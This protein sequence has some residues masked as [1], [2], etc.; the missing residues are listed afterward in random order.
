MSNYDQAELAAEFDDVVREDPS[1]LTYNLANTYGSFMG[2]TERSL[3]AEFVVR[4][5]FD[6]QP[7][8]QRLI[9]QGKQYD[10]DAVFLSK[11][12]PEDTPDARPGVE[13]YFKETITPEQMATV[14]E[15]LRDKGV[16]GFTY[17]TDMRFDD[18]VNRQTRPGDPETA[19]LNGLRFQYVPEFDDT[20]DP[21]KA[22][23]SYNK[24]ADLFRSVVNDTVSDGNVSDARITYYDTEVYFR[25]DYD[26][27]LSRTIKEGSSGAGGDL[28]R[29]AN[30]PKS[31][32]GAEVGTE[33]PTDVPDG[34]VQKT[35]SQEITALNKSGDPL[36][37]NIAVDKNGTDYADLI[38]N[39][40]KKFESRETASLK[41]YVGKRVGIVRTGAGPAEVIGS[42]EIGQ[43]IEVNEKQFNQLRDQHLVAEDSSFNIKK[44]QTKFLYPM[45]DPTSTPPQK[46][47]S[48][49]IVARAVPSPIQ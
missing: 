46:V 23:E 36:G 15:R 8:R 25:D 47:T 18:R 38:V 42:V 6:P 24:A 13:I 4:E 2:D 5:N 17:V 31:N 7:L 41:P 16:D 19:G 1:V 37:I 43:P 22:T 29:G 40:T 10:Q 3:N 27:Q 32:R 44:G 9:E 21:Q 12:V 20:F 33:L 39:G 11:V 30:D 35:T 45:M 49:G 14:T 34:I 48:K 28:S 26:E